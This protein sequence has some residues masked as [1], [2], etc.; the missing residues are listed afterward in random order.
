MTSEVV[1][2]DRRPSYGAAMATRTAGPL[3]RDW[4]VR[5]RR[6]QMDLAHEVG[7]SPRH[8]SFVETGRSRPS[9]ELLLALAD[10]LEVPLRDRNVLLLAAGYAPRYGERS[11]DDAAMV[12]ARAALQRML[13]T[14][15][16]YPGVVIDRAW[17]V[18]LTNRAAGLLMV[19]LPPE[20]LGPPVNVF[21]VCLHPDGLA[22]RTL[23]FT[24]WS[25]IPPGSAAPDRDPDRR[26][27]APC[28]R[29]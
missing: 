16:P 10:R 24:E 23:N 29:R 2:A 1:V 19:G 28:T 20:L 27:V 5:R 4:R 6:S 3:V 15:D 18:V 22:R 17:N 25:A 14:H 12:R 9:P 26:R 7:V 13:D 21:R 8:L 11:L